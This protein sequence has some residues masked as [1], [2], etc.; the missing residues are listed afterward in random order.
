MKH[1][2]TEIIELRLNM[3]YVSQSKHPASPS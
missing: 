2:R 1:W 3:K